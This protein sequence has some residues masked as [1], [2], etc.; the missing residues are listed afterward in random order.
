MPV[1]HLS[2][3]PYDRF[4]DRLGAADASAVP[5]YATAHDWAEAAEGLIHTFEKG[6]CSAVGHLENGLDGPHACLQKRAVLQ[7][8][9]NTE[10]WT[11]CSRHFG[12]P[13]RLGPQIKDASR[14][15]VLTTFT[16][17]YGRGLGPTQAARH[18]QGCV[19]ADQLPFADRR[20]V[21][22]ADPRAA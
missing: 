1:S 12:R 2:Q 4:W 7:S 10:H 20:H 22:T 14:R 9:S 13:S 6:A 3:A 18:L 11:H 19:S 15:Y 17:A 16:F 21:D 5:A 8:L